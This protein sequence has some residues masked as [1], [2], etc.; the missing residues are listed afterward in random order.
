MIDEQKLN[1]FQNG[2]ALTAED[3]KEIFRLARWGLKSK[4]LFNAL[5]IIA[6]EHL[7]SDKFDQLSEDE[8]YETVI[9]DTD[10][11][12]SALNEFR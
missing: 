6:A 5:K 2:L 10:I 7:S 3:A 8:L 12:R 1:Q 9:K 11:A 4:I